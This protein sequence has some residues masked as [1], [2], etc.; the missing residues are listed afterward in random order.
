MMSTGG[1]CL[2]VRQA[3]RY[4]GVAPAK[5]RRWIR[6]G[7]LQAIDVGERRRALRIPPSAIRDFEVRAAV[8]S[9]AKKPRASDIDPEI[10]ALLG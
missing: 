6:Q 5:V 4:F 8:R 2:S 1:Y 10:V 3:A 7:L 9:T